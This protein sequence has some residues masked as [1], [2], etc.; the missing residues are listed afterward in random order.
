[1]LAKCVTELF[2]VTEGTV[3]LRTAVAIEMKGGCLQNEMFLQQTCPP[4]AHT[5]N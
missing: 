4:P 3:C 2:S 5:L 1:M